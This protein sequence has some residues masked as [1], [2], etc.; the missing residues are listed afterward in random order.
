MDNG[1]WALNSEVIL[2]TPLAI[3]LLEY[4]LPVIMSALQYNDSFFFF[5]IIPRFESRGSVLEN[6]D[7]SLFRSTYT[8]LRSRIDLVCETRAIRGWADHH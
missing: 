5:L 8:I 1:A 6:G 7:I 4:D 3:I 2:D